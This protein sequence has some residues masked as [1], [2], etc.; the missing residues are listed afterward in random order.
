MQ[1]NK[2]TNNVPKSQILFFVTFQNQL[3]ENECIKPHLKS[4]EQQLHFSVRGEVIL[5]FI[6][7]CNEKFSTLIST[8]TLL[9]FCI[10]Y[11]TFC[12]GCEF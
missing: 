6:F 9:I 2:T 10:M 8:L 11:V 3:I 7:H 12:T 1:L 4:K 5:K